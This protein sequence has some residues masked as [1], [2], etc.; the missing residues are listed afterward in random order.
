MSSHSRGRRRESH[1]R[2]QPN[3]ASDRGGPDV[4]GR[5]DDMNDY[6]PLTLHVPEP[7]VRPGGVPDFSSVRVPT[8]GSV[9]RPEVNADPETIRDLAYSIIRVLKS[10]GQAVGP[11]SGLLDD[12]E[13]LQGLRDM[14]TLRAFDARMVMAKRRSV[15]LSARRSCRAT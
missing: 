5:Y 10:D 9:P 7:A 14:M 13:L 1:R 12:D 6:A 4:N 2:C 3:R 8:A 15:A 11:W